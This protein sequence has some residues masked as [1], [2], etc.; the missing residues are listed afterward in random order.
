MCIRVFGFIARFN[1]SCHRCTFLTR[2]DSMIVIGSDVIEGCL[3]RISIGIIVI[4]I[5]NNYAIG[6][7]VESDLGLLGVAVLAATSTAEMISI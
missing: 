1:F 3:N 2:L 7:V 4:I 5:G 6:Q